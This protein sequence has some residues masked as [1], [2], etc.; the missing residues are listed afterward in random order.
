MGHRVRVAFA[1]TSG[2]QSQPAR[3]LFVDEMAPRKH[4]RRQV[5]DPSVNCGTSTLPFVSGPI[6]SAKMKTNSFSAGWPALW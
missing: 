2:S 4:D 1:G 6:S 5:P 3:Y